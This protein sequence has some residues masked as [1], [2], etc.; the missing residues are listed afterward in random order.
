MKKETLIQKMRQT[1]YRKIKDQS[2]RGW[3]PNALKHRRKGRKEKIR[4]CWEVKN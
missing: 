1:I 3:S 4:I 2:L